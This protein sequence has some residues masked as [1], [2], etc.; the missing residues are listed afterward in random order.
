MGLKGTTVKLIV[1]YVG[2]LLNLDARLV[3]LA[4]FLGIPC[5]TLALTGVADY[6]EFLKRTTPDHCSCFVVNPR[7]IERWIL[8]DD[9]PFDLITLFLSRFPHLLV[10][11]VRVEAFDTKLVA[12]LSRGKLTSVDAID[13]EHAFYAIAKDSKRVCDSFAGISFG[14][15]NPANDHVFKTDDDDPAVEP[16]IS[17]SGRPFMAAVRLVGTEILFLASEDVA[18]LDAPV[19]ET[20]LTEYFSKLVPH[21]M[22][23]RYVAGDECWRPS[24]AHASI[25]ID[26]PLLQERYGF[27]KFESLLRLEEQHNF[28]TTIAFIPHNFRRNSPRIT[29]MFLENAER[30]SICFHGNDH[31][32]GEFASTD[33]T[34]LNTLLRTAQDRMNS[35]RQMTGLPCDKV[36]VFPQGDFSI[37]AMKAVKSHNFYAVV[38]RIS[39]LDQPVQLTIG[40][41]V[42][43]A[44]LRFGGFPLFIRSPIQQIQS[45][46]IAFNLF[47]GR[48]VL[49]GEHHDVFQSP[50]SLVGIA[51]KINSVAPKIHWP[52][53]AT[54]VSDSVLTRRTP[55]GT[56]HVRAYSGTVRI[57]NESGSARRFSIE[58]GASWNGVPIEQVLMNG[59]LCGGFEIDDAGPRLTVELAPGSS[60][61][62]SLVHRNV[63]STVRDLGLAW[64]ARAFSRRR[65]S[66]VRDNYLSKNQRLLAIAKVL[67]RRFLTRKPPELTN[68]THVRASAIRSSE[69]SAGIVARDS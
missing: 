58:W 2:K 1:P 54:V 38:N 52:N 21:A 22:A 8:S 47:F 40:D 68:D 12:A 25:V 51:A 26:D 39:H 46:D 56:Q 33:A 57:S 49:I 44:V 60:Q 55:D 10:H 37:E 29:R 11:A 48:P 15:V 35:H 7:V 62:F 63:D 4:Q 69:L 64:K 6:A 50:E 65:L 42:Q 18:D 53:L 66:E 32:G 17:I 28:H 41:L 20:P 16:L 67:Q 9:F 23:L 61:T 5:E 27:L 30:L 14:P 19:G 34:L 43:P 24:R 59:T 13:G 45:Q 3:R 36:M 31:T